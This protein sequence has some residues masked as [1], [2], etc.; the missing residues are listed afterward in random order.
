MSRWWRAYDEA[1]DDPKLQRIGPALG[2]AWFNLMCISSKNDGALPS[3]GDVAFKLRTTEQKAAA[4]IAALVSAGLFDR[5][6][7][8]RYAPHNWSGRQ[9]RG[10][11]TDPTNAERQ[12]RYR[13]RHRN[14][15]TTVTAGVTRKR[16]D[17]ETDTETETEKKETRAGALADDWPGDFREQFWAGYPN[18]VGKPK[19]IAKLEG[20]RKR[21][22]KF[23]HIMGGLGRYVASKPPDR[24][25][26]N[27]ETFINQ[28]RWSDQPA[29]IEQQNGQR[30]SNSRTTG[31]DA[32]LAAA[33]REAGKIARD[34][35]L[36]GAAPEAEFPFG[37]F[38]DRSRAG[39]DRRPPQLA[40]G[41]NDRREPAAGRVFEGEVIAPDQASPRV[42]NGWRG[43]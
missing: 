33:T 25:W 21:G 9:Y 24:A 42:S 3:I 37:D 31:H 19:A 27:P 2:W 8:G 22:V 6:E 34:D 10:D 36:A 14:G 16:P 13:E 7:D 15:V 32:I 26:L 1:V 28:E 11:V 40:A 38:S 39:M 35:E 41:N 4:T 17:T 12:K 30:T 29:T 5:R 43:H 23:S 20:C 18:K